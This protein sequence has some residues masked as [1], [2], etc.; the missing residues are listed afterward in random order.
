MA[1]GTLRE[2]L[3]S[4]LHQHIVHICFRDCCTSCLNGRDLREMLEDV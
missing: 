1:N 2:Y 4:Q 3:L